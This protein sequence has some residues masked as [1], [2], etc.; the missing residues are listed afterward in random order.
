MVELASRRSRLNDKLLLDRCEI[1]DDPEGTFDD[2]TNPL[3][4]AVTGPTPD[5]VL[6]CTTPCKLK[7]TLRYQT[8]DEGGVP[9]VV[10]RYE[11]KLPIPLPAGEVKDGQRIK[12][13]VSEHDPSLVGKW[14]RV[15]EVEYG[16]LT[17]FR[18]V[19]VELRERASDRP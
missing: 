18:R 8:A 15:A 2:V 14:L 19:S 12:M 5:T 17:V 4:G 16:S 1:H 6:V 13:T 11:L 7:L 9:T 3:T 10:S